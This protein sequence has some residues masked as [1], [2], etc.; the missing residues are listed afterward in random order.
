MV[1]PR[2][3]CRIEIKVSA[4]FR[5]IDGRQVYKKGNTIGL[6]VDPKEY[7]FVELVKDVQAY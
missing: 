3:D 5:V 7:A 4:Y 6:T 2:A 1:N